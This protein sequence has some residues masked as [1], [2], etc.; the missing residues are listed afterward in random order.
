MFQLFLH[1]FSD[2]SCF[3]HYIMRVSGVYNAVVRCKG[4][5][6]DIRSP[7]KGLHLSNNESQMQCRDREENFFCSFYNLIL[8]YLHSS[9]YFHSLFSK[10]TSLSTPK[11]TPICLIIM[12]L[13]NL[14]DLYS[15]YD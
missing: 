13:L 4:Y 14:M 15:N 12:I 2:L 11:N 10:I 3:I 9:W 7:G 8:K 5:L 1:G 6:L